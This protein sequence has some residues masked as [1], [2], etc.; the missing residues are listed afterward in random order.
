MEREKN[1]DVLSDTLHHMRLQS[2]LYGRLHLTEPWG[3]LLEPSTHANY[4]LVLEQDQNKNCY[5]TLDSDKQKPI[6]IKKGDF[7]LL[8]RVNGYR[9]TDAIGRPTVDLIKY[10]QT[11]AADEAK[12][13]T[14]DADSVLII[15]CFQFDQ[16]HTNPLIKSLPELI[17]IHNQNGAADAN[18]LATI[19]LIAMES[20]RSGARQGIDFTVS[21]LTEV[22]LAQAIRHMA[23]NLA[24]C[25]ESRSWLK[26][27]ID[28]Q[29]GRAIAYIHEHPGSTITLEIL[30][31]HCDMSRSAFAQRFAALT[32]FTPAEY[33]TMWRMHKAGLMLKEQDHKIATIADA[34]GYNSEAAF[35]TA[36]RRVHKVAPGQYRQLAR[37]RAVD[38][39]TGKTPITSD[40][41]PLVSAL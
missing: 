8:P 41:R 27:L 25:E 5:I 26:A 35:S 13:I 24:R 2:A 31:K 33:V 19:N 40:N 23:S 20:E 37:E 14:T 1:M 32:D 3:F 34:V 28:P 10:F 16:D 11:G 30:A 29:I 36:F 6:S 7:L 38:M 39:G 15:G 22:L 12:Q 9:L 21:R 17:H 4:C 18:L